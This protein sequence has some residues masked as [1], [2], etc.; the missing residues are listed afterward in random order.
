MFRGPGV[1]DSYFK[2][3]DATATTKTADGWVH[4][5]DAGVFDEDGHLKIIDRAQDVGRL[6]EGTLFAPKHLEN[7]L[8]FFPYINEAVACGQGRDYSAVFVIIDRAAADD[9]AE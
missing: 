8:K 1:F 5:G 2:S 9:G 7:K 4:T 6:N 3:P